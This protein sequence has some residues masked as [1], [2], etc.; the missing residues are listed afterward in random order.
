MPN[1]YEGPAGNNNDSDEYEAIM[2]GEDQKGKNASCYVRNIVSGRD[3]KM[4]KCEH[5]FP[6]VSS[7]PGLE[8]EEVGDGH[9]GL[10]EEQFW[11]TDPNSNDT[12]GSGIMDEAT[13][14][15]LGK[16]QFKWIYS[17]GD[18]IGVAV[19]GASAL[20]T[21]DYDS[22]YKIMWAITNN[23]DILEINGLLPDEE[24]ED[25]EDEE[26]VEEEDENEEEDEEE[27]D[28]NEGIGTP[29]K[30]HI[31]KALEEAFVEPTVGTDYKKISNHLSVNNSNPQY[32]TS[33]GGGKS[34]T[35]TISS[36]ATNNE[37]KNF[38]NYKWQLAIAS[39][40][41][42]SNWQTL[43]QTD[44]GGKI[45]LEG[46]GLTE[47]KIPFE[48]IKKETLAAKGI[49]ENAKAFYI[50][51]T[52]RTK[53]NSTQ[54]ITKEG[55]E[56][57]II[58][59]QNSK[60]E[61]EVYTGTLDASGN[62]IQGA[63]KCNTGSEQFVCPVTPD[64]IIAATIPS[65][66][67][68][69]NNFL[70]S[71]SLNEKRLPNTEN[72]ENL[73]YFPI[74]ERAGSTYNLRV[75]IANKTSSESVTFI[76]SF[77]VSNPSAKIKSATSSNLSPVLLG[78]FIDEDEALQW[79]HYSED[80]FQ[81]IEGSTVQMQAQ[82]NTPTE[83][84]TTWFVDGQQITASENSSSEP[85]LSN[86]GNTLNLP[87]KKSLGEKY[88]ISSSTSRKYDAST[89]ALLYDEWGISKSNLSENNLS[90]SITV[91]VSDNI[92]GKASPVTYDKINRDK[93]LASLFSGLPDYIFF[94]FKIIVTFALILFSSSLII[95]ISPERKEY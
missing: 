6:D 38:T 77:S 10:K 44:L 28:E 88:T 49:A 21:E 90:K 84:E 41:D 60:G 68:S 43:N 54:G 94:L 4:D 14:S 80:Y 12:S 40:P 39:S 82:N 13:V 19:E 73:V 5:L 75:D 81:A 65:S 91:I 70:F 83:G 47:L 29:T 46:I 23:P 45:E 9:F 89:K 79:P 31:N 18:K 1:L 42:A 87:I 53:E 17:P 27:E 66:Q 24:E 11:R 30:K 51:A 35:I 93:V 57:M 26:D 74:T 36:N 72:S 58:T 86:N 64:E 85:F 32:D 63:Q 92:N 56:T 52:L 25:E 3:V 34:D 2:G 37:N 67:Y 15:G 55:V 16:L 20:A 7:Y 22:S 48:S 8:D 71:W 95:S 33:T 59:V 76:R 50:R 62:L 78:H 61:I 69:P